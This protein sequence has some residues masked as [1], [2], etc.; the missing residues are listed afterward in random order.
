V[1][2]RILIADSNR[3]RGKAIAEACAARDIACD[4]AVQG[5]EALETAL[6]DRPCAAV[7]ELDLPLIDGPRL[8]SILRSNPHT[9]GLVLLYLADRQ[10]DASEDLDGD[11]MLAPIDPDRVARRIQLAVMQVGSRREEQ[12][13]PPDAGGVEGDLTQIPL[14]DLLQLF[15]T[16][17]KTGVV[18]LAQIEAN[19]EGQ[20]GRVVVDDGDVT[21]A[22]SGSVQG[23]KALYRLLAWDRGTFAFHPKR[24]SERPRIQEST[25]T[26]LQEGLRQLHEW[27]RLTLELPPA[28][29]RVRLVAARDELPDPLHPLTQE[30][31]DVLGQ[32]SRV[33]DIVDACPSPDYQVLRTLQTLIERGV[34]ALAHQTTDAGEPSD[35]V[36]FS[37]A[38]IRRL[39]EWLGAGRP[40]DA[41]TPDAKLLVV[42]SDDRAIGEFTRLLRTLPGVEIDARHASGTLSDDLGPLALVSVEEDLR[43]EILNLPA[44]A[45]FAPVWP[46]AGA[47]ALGIVFLTS[48]PVAGS[49]GATRGCEDALRKLPRSRIFHV[50]LVHKDEEE[51]REAL[52][53]NVVLLE[54]A[55]LF[56]VPLE[57]DHRARAQLRDLFARLLP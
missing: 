26:L 6:V 31:L 28:D 32:H 27:S 18:E 21:H 36:L 16:G 40:R 53:Q 1:S 13:P 25:R 29:A 12:Q 2:D 33:R 10:P 41:A 4:L 37:A 48:S 39:R 35:A 19:G 52:L 44:D 51:A 24:V 30:V 11:V 8:A 47:G 42:A 50:A 56:V 46:V 54:E 49:I 45:S 55:S 7:V 17:R 20:S 43:I 5:P 38:Q 9:E 3:D 15:H 22:E 23:P 14:S 57:S 34:I